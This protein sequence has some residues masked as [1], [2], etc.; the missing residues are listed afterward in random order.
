MWEGNWTLYLENT[1]GSTV[2]VPVRL[3]VSPL[4]LG[5]FALW[6]TQHLPSKGGEVTQPDGPGADT[7]AHGDGEKSNVPHE[8]HYVVHHD[9]G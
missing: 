5:V 4:W 1:Q 7:K 3:H 9:I 8:D 6:V 2:S